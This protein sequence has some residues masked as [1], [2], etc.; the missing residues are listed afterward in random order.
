M[1]KK[2]VLI[3]VY[4][5]PPAGGPG[6]QR[7][8]KF[9]KYLPQFNVEPIVYHP[10]NPIYPQIDNS[11]LDEVPINITILKQPINEP[12]KLAS[13]FSKKTTKTISKGIFPDEKKQTIV[14][15]AML[16]VRGNFFIPDARKNWINPSVKYLSSYIKDHDID[17]IITSGPPHSLH[18]IGL[19]L[20]HSMNVNWIA[21]FRDPWTTIGYHKQLKLTKASRNKHKKLESEVLNNADTIIVTSNVTKTEF[22]CL[23]KKPI[24]VI[25]NGYDVETIS[26]QVLDKQFTLA[27][28]G[29]FLSKRNPE[30]LWQALQELVS[31]NK[32]FAKCFK[33]N[34]VG[35]VGEEIINA[36]ERND[37]TKYLNNVGYVSHI[38]SLGY[39]QKSQILLLVEIDSKD[40][41]AIIPGKLFEYMVS[42]RPIIAIGPAGSDVESI[43]NKT[44]TGD[45]F[46]YDALSELKM[47]LLVHFEAFKIGS[48]KANPIGVSQY[49]RE[50][51]TK[52][53]S[54]VILKS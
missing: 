6:I 31:E 15:K 22:Q 27:H 48:L 38:E 45:Y 52:K 28:I 41:K 16:F 21:D 7:W 17:T 29:S 19:K 26:S 1:N 33:L 44:N 35:L 14:Q 40:T 39:Q 3:I 54:E 18:L 10:S 12:Y 20:K 13:L 37:L 43:I 34:L 50:N 46:Y 53:L 30:I 32:D 25:T 8:L 47:K 51:L 4:Y 42:N 9:V 11:L 5:W 23:T 24:E 49:S 2:K 36:I